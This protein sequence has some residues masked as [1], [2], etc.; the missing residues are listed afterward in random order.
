MQQTTIAREV[1]IGAAHKPVWR[2][3]SEPEQIGRRLLPPALGAQLPGDAERRL[4]V[5]MGPT[6][7][8]PE[9]MQQGVKP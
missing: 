4:L 8:S 7:R 2:A 9:V 6:M 5:G 3:V 1:W